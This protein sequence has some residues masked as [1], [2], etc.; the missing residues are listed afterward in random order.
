MASIEF[1]GLRFAVE[2]RTTTGYQSKSFFVIDHI[3]EDKARPF[4][5]A[6]NELI[7]IRTGLAAGLVIFTPALCGLA[8]ALNLF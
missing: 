7:A 1:A 2:N 8:R 4:Y 5:R 6:Y 3:D